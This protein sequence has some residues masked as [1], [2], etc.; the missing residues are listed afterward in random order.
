MTNTEE[1]IQIER[2]KLMAEVS[3]IDVALSALRGYD[4]IPRPAKERATRVKVTEGANPTI[5]KPK[6]GAK[7]GR[8][9][10]EE[11]KAKMRAAHAARKAAQTPQAENVAAE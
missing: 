10:S 7:P 4:G 11:T 2:A 6:R 8:V 9:V 1:L 5:A 3:R